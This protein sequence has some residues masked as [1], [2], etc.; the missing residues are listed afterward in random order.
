[1]IIVVFR[2]WKENHGKGVIALFPEMIGSC[3]THKYCQSY[4]HIGQGG[5]ADPSGVVKASRSATET[6]RM[7]LLKELQT[8][9]YALD[10]REKLTP[11]M[12]S[13]RRAN[14]RNMNWE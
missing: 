14:F 9:G 8:I 13:N 3:H 4:E 10:V 5:S 6:E 7:P 12:N 2:V 11:Q 1:M